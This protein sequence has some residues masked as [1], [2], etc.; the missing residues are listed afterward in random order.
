MRGGVSLAAAL[1]LPVLTAAGHPFPDRSTV[2]FVAYVTIAA[3]LVLPGLTLSRLVRALGLAEEEAVAREEAEARVQMAHAAL[4]RI[5]DVADR[6]HLQELLVDQVRMAYEL[7]IQ[8]LE[9]QLDGGGEGDEATVAGRARELRR[10]L[11]GVERQ[12]LQELRRRGKVSAQSQRRIEHELDL[13]ESRLGGDDRGSGAWVHEHHVDECDRGQLHPSERLGSTDD[14]GFSPFSIDEK[15]RDSSPDFAG[16][17]A[18]E[19]IANRAGHQHGGR[20]P[21]R[22]IEP[23]QARKVGRNSTTRTTRRYTSPRTLMLPTPGLPG[24]TAH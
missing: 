14:Y 8:R 18:F 21:R 6:E 1:A 2:V 17:V 22:S 7:R 10:E 12:R 3:T 16:D 4:R 5:E 19:K 11:I 24:T 9:P 13:E 20:E 23:R 15:P